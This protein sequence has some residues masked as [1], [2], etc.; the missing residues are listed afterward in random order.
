MVESQKLPETLFTPSTKAEQGEHDENLHPD[1]GEPIYHLHTVIQSI[2]ICI[3][4]LF[5]LLAAK[6][7]G[8]D[9]YNQI[10]AVSLA[11]YNA[12]ST[13]AF[14]RGLILADT[15]FEFGLLASG[16]LILIDE[17]LTPDSSRYW[18]ADQYKPGGPQ[19][20]FDKQFVRDWLVKEGFRKGLE[21]GKKGHEGEGWMIAPD[22]VEGT[23]ERYKEAVDRLMGE[24]TK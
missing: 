10:S 11:L 23:R 24:A 15:K 20:S 12:A 2:S 7:I 8:Q 16:Q 9:L 4:N 13:Y 1:A 21:S 17:L 18:P 22:V 14:S 19:P 3:Y 6:I 5:Q